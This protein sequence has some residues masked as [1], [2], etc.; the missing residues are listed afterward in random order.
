MFFKNPKLNLTANKILVHLMYM[1]ACTTY[2]LLK[3][4]ETPENCYDNAFAD[5]IINSADD[6]DIE[7]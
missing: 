5:A 6:D 7:A 1:M 4:L 3:I 2:G